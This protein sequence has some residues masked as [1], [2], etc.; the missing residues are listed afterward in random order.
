[1]TRGRSESSNDR[2]GLHKELGFLLLLLF[3]LGCRT[4]QENI[5]YYNCY[6]GCTNEV[7]ESGWCCE[8]PVATYDRNFFDCKY[9]TPERSINGQAH[10]QPV[11]EGPSG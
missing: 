9:A 7:G 2:A 6:W 4:P 3:I 5:V 11:E 1:M 10:E 8:R